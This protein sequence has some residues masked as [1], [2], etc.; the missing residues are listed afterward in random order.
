[1]RKE[2]ARFRRDMRTKPATP[3]AFDREA[4]MEYFRCHMRAAVDAMIEEQK[5]N[6]PTRDDKHEKAKS[7]TKVKNFGVECRTD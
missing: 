1:M 6:Q 3:P 4:L 5:S 7:K 2:A